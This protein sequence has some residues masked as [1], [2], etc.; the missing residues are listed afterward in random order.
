MF[1]AL[2]CR[3]GGEDG[4]AGGVPRRWQVGGLPSRR[5]GTCVPATGCR[6][7]FPP[8]SLGCRGHTL[9][10]REECLVPDAVDGQ[11]ILD[12]SLLHC[13]WSSRTPGLAGGGAEAL[14]LGGLS[15]VVREK[16]GGVSEPESGGPRSPSYGAPR[17]APFPG[18]TKG[19]ASMC[20]AGSS[21]KPLGAVARVL[22]QTALKR[23]VSAR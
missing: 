21:P 13:V 4:G 10:G 18:G 22:L 6:L 11:A 20:P 7:L 19:E 23:L 17:M 9:N 14:R 12:H 15:K 3:R 1:G 16:G 5:R 8:G 2:P